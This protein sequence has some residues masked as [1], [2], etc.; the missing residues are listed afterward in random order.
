MSSILIN[1]SNTEEKGKKV[2][3]STP[4]AIGV[5]NGSN[6]EE[7]GKKDRGRSECKLRY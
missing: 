6:T 1:G 4:I 5:I 3:S 2:V 7:K